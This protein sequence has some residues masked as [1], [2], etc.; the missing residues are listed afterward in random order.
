MIEASVLWGVEVLGLVDSLSAM[1]IVRDLGRGGLH[2]R[3]F[4]FRPAPKPSTL[5]HLE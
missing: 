1:T 2:L 5:M 4:G 3:D